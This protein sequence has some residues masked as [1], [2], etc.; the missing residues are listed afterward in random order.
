MNHFA[1]EHFKKSSQT[2]PFELTDLKVGWSLPFFFRELKLKKK[3]EFKDTSN[4]TH[5]IPRRQYD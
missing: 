3:K 4:A 1:N 5:M 2:A